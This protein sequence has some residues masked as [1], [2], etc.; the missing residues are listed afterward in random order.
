MKIRYVIALAVV[1]GFGAGA[2]AVQVL[3]AQAKPPAYV[4]VE[5]DVTNNDAFLKEYAPIAGNAIGAGGGK[6][7]ARGGKNVAIDGEPP[8]P[9]TV[10]IAFD[11]M[12]QAQAT[13]ASAA[14]RDGRKIGDK[15]AKFRIWATEGVAK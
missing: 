12:E 3:H 8:K 10:V 15:Y 11:S 2:A 13:F 4:V 1:A 5:I 9:R 6:Y 7:L 14:Y